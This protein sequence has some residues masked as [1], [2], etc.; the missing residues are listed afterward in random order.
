MKTLSDFKRDLLSANTMIKGGYFNTNKNKDEW[1]SVEKAQSNG[2]WLKGEDGKRFFEYP[3][4]NAC[5]YDGTTLKIY[6]TGWRELNEEE[7]RVIAEWKEIANTEE[8]K[9]RAE[10]DILTDGSS[11][12]WQ[13]RGFYERYNMLYL[14]THDNKSSKYLDYNRYHNGE[15]LC[16]RDN[17]APHG[18]QIAEYTIK[19]GE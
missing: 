5:E 13:E 1:R 2:A 7:K 8:Y 3:K 9:K 14:F 15:K 18:K 19:K 17:Q 4:A 12:F 6:E 16:V 10:I 11:T